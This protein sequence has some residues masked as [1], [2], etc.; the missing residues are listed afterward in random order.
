MAKASDYQRRINAATNQVARNL[1][2]NHSIEELA[3]VANFSKFHFHRIYRALS[4]ETVSQM[5]SRLRLE[6]AAASLIY[7]KSLPITRGAVCLLYTSPSP[8][9]S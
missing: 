5:V 7:N 9:D 4:G 6:G 3:A 8:R 2:K 1:D